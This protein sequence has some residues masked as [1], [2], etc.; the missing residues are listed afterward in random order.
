MPDPGTT[1]DS[2]IDR[3]GGDAPAAWPIAA[4]V[5]L[6]G[7]LLLGWVLLGWNFSKPITLYV[8]DVLVLNN[9]ID[10]DIAELAGPMEGNQVAPFGFLV[11][12][13]SAVGVLGLGLASVKATAFVSAVLSVPV[14]AALVRRMCAPLPGLIV[15]LGFVTSVE[16][17][18]QA[19]R[20]KPYTMDVLLALLGLWVGCWVL[21]RRL[22]WRESAVLTLLAGVGVWF[23]IAFYIVLAGVGGVLLVTRLSRERR[24]ELAWLLLPAGVGVV[25]GACHY[26]LILRGQMAAADTDAY[27]TSFWQSGFLPMPWVSPGGLVSGLARGVGDATGLALP[28]LVLGLAVLGAGVLLARRG[29]ARGW[30]LLAPWGVAVAMSMA[31]VY[32][33][34]DR[35]ALYLGPAVL[36]LAA[37]GLSGLRQAL[38]GRA[39][40]VLLLLAGAAILSGPI[41]RRGVA[42]FDDDVAPVFRHVHDHLEPGQHVYLFYGT[43]WP[44]EFYTQHM[45]PAL[46]F[47]ADRLTRGGKHRDDALRYGDEVRAL[48]GHPEVWLIFSHAS[49]H[50]GI[51][52]EAYFKLLLDRYGQRIAEHRAWGAFAILWRP[53]PADPPGATA[54][55]STP[56]AES[57]AR[58]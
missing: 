17:L 23:S 7:L 41:Q 6:V 3:R 54:D 44:Y 35:L 49:A 32:P 18:L 40:C 13:W 12:V 28:G 47:P 27:M 8:D 46:A 43:Y 45:D 53:D 29:S 1:S 33:L 10:A 55:E 39:G 58:P 36:L 38:P 19:C 11:A 25:S 21:E 24:R 30:L 48:R 15:M 56:A 16:F 57:P 20:V 42:A 31:G 14:F 9:V 37:S 26:A 50:G 34:G 4:R 52:E 51:D 22:G 2:S 5:G